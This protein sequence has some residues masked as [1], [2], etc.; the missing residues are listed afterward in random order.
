MRR[1][2]IWAIGTLALA[3]AAR[4]DPPP[5]PV[6]S[7]TT[8]PASAGRHQTE[9]VIPDARFDANA[10]GDIGQFLRQAFGVR[11]VVLRDACT[12][13]M[14]AISLKDVTVG[15]LFQIL[16]DA[17]PGLTVQEVPADRLTPAV[18]VI[19]YHDPDPA[20]RNAPADPATPH[21]RVFGLTDSVAPRAAAAAAAA[22]TGDHVKGAMNDVL[23]AI[24]TALDVAALPGPSAVLK[25]HQPT[26]TLVARGTDAQLDLI[27][28]TVAALRPSKDELVQA[29]TSY[30]RA[31]SGPQKSLPTT[32]PKG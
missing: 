15:Q 30:M 10:I 24:Q 4:G 23:S 12:L 22:D 11:V 8:R 7:A 13:P 32:Q 28:Q 5:L 21:V 2:T 3:T 25:V 31:D 1:G 29:L 19:G 6:A 27:A 20:P 17:H 18:Y 9:V 16:Q 14:P 26:L